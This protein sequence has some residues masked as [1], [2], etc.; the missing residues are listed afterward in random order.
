MHEPIIYDEKDHFRQLV[1]LY[2]DL[3]HKPLTTYPEMV[4]AA[5][6]RDFIN[7]ERDLLN[8]PLCNIHMHF[9]ML[10]RVVWAE[11]VLYTLADRE[12]KRKTLLSLRESYREIQRWPKA[13]RD[14]LAPLFEHWSVVLNEDEEVC[15]G[16][17]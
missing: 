15:R 16:N 13:W 7:L 4:K 12:T 8:H 11:A 17:A 1:W 9:A 3:R 5:L 2:S 10:A 6:D 14:A